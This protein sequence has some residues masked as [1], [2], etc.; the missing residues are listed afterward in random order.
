MD[1]ELECL[2]RD[3]ELVLTV[4]IHFDDLKL[5]G[6]PEDIGWFIAQLEETFGK[7]KANWNTLTKCGIRHFRNETSGAITLDQHDLHGL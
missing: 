7:L 2:H 5:T 4:A 3:G 6:A 1:S